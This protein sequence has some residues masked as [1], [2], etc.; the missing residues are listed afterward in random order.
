MSEPVQPATETLSKASSELNNLLQII[1]GATAFIE[2]NSAGK[3]SAAENLGVLRSTIGRAERLAATLARQAGGTDKKELMH[4]DM[5]S[6]IRG[7]NSR[8]TK[9]QVRSVLLV[10]DEEMALTLVKRVLVG[11]GFEVTTAS[12][13][14]QCLDLVRRQQHVYDLVLLDLTMPF[15][16]GEETFKR[17]REIRADLPVVLCTGFI[18]QERLSRL[19]SA[20]LAGFLRKPIAADEIVSFVRATFANVKYTRGSFD[21]HSIP[22]AI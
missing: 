5:A 4:P 6:F 13:G 1:S 3:E 11:A 14:F 21:P 7:R 12:S 20:G 2:E 15:M 19:M 17:L 16:D 22:L 8:S 10:D 9:S 18:Q